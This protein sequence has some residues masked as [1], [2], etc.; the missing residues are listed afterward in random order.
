MADTP[1]LNVVFLMDC[2]LV[3]LPSLLF[4]L[5]HSIE[6]SSGV[7]RHEAVDKLGRVSFAFQSVIQV[8]PTQ[9]IGGAVFRVVHASI[10]DKRKR[11]KIF[12]KKEKS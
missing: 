5:P 9:E 4:H 8:C 6:Y 3:Y 2:W 11:S 12:E 10:R 1:Y 7:W